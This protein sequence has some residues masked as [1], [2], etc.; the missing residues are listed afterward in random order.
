MRTLD[1][2]GMNIDRAMERLGVSS[3]KSLAA[4]V[5]RSGQEV[6]PN[7]TFGRWRTGKGPYAFDQLDL[8]AANL[9]T[10]PWELVAPADHLRSGALSLAALQLARE[11]DACTRPDKA[12]LYV[13]LV[14]EI[15]AGPPSPPAAPPEG[16]QAPAPDKPPTVVPLVRSRRHR[17]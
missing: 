7:G 8:L 2:V 16:T 15:R 10:Q 11:F 6:F 1:L 12:D 13:R 9:E 5:R 3:W 17:G 4:R 14:A